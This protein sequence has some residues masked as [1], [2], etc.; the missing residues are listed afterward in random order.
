MASCMRPST[1]LTAGGSRPSACPYVRFPNPDVVDVRA[2]ARSSV[3]PPTGASVGLPTAAPSQSSLSQEAEGQES[4]TMPS[5]TRPSTRLAANFDLPPKINNFPDDAIARGGGRVRSSTRRAAA[6]TRKRLAALFKGKAAEAERDYDEAVLTQTSGGD[7]LPRNH[8]E[9]D[10]GEQEDDDMDIDVDP[11]PPPFFYFADP[12]DDGSPSDMVVEWPPV[13]VPDAIEY[14]GEGPP[15][16]PAMSG[17]RWPGQEAV[18]EATGDEE[19]EMPRPPPV[20]AGSKRK[21]QGASEEEVRPSKVLRGEPSSSEGGMSAAARSAAAAEAEAAAVTAEVYAAAL[22][23]AARLTEAVE[24]T[25]AAAA[26]AAARRAAAAA[27]EEAALDAEEEAIAAA[28]AEAEAAAAADEERAR[29]REAFDA[30]QRA[31]EEGAQR[32]QR[33]SSRRRGAGRGGRGQRSTLLLLR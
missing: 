21:G 5:A 31:R 9:E 25:E 12:W 7:Y 20:F 2:A 6:E 4:P 17:V 26:A 32:R 16:P 10:G 18:A 22:V 28:F 8:E 30:A 19:E 24:R 3:L 13:V 14:E 15:P 33:P 11:D 23:D 1:L 29:H 27:E